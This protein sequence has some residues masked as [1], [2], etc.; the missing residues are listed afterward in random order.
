MPTGERPLATRTVWLDELNLANASQGSG[1]PQKNKSVGGSPLTLGGRKFETTADAVLETFGGPAGKAML[2][3]MALTDPRLNFRDLLFIERGI[4]G[5]IEYDGKHCCDQYY[6]HNGRPGGGLY[7]LKNAFSAN[8]AKVDL[9]AGK[10]VTQGLMAGKSLAGGSFGSLDLSFDGKR[11]AFGWSPGGGTKWERQNRSR[12]FVCD[13]T[14]GNLIQLTG[15][16]NADDIQPC[17]LPGDERIVFMSTRRGGFGRCHP[18]PVPSYVLHSMK[19][20]GSDLYGIDWHETNEWH[21]SVANDGMLVYTRWD[22][23]DRDAVITHH[24]WKCWPDGPAG[25]ESA[26]HVGIQHPGDSGDGLQVCGGVR[27]ASWPG[28]RRNCGPGCRGAR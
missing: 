10:T 27:T 26:P 2:R 21:P 3:S 6:G 23:V 1:T 9:L 4:L 18:R 14:G 11:I 13:I 12:I 17:W 15:D 8:P 22:Y 24:F 28:V 16:V 25:L 19:S 7:V 5:G 20:D